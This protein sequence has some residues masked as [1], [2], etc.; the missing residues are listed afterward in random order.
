MLGD[1]KCWEIK[2]VGLF[3]CFAYR[4]GIGILI[5]V[6]LFTQPFECQTS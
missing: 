1:Q 6:V 2:N 4:N 3:G 5:S